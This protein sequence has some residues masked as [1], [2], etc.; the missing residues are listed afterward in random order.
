MQTY[1]NIKKIHIFASITNQFITMRK[2]LFA[3]AILALSFTACKDNNS[4]ATEGAEEGAATEV[5]HKTRIDGGVAY[6]NIDSLLAKYDLATELRNSFEAKYNKID[7]DLTARYS[8]LERDMMDAQEKV[9]KGLVTRA[10]A[11]ELEEKLVKQQQRFVQ[12]REKR[13]GELAEEEQVINNRLYYAVTDYLKE[14]NADFKYS[15]IMSTGAT[16]PVLH[17][18]PEF[19]ITSEVLAALNEAYAKEKAAEAAE[20]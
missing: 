12:D 9:Q 20:K 10:Q 7:K 2:I 3:A 18:D 16:G 13:M 1:T 6:I 14:Y 11:A 4:A 17:A 8:R 5:N 19:D 15:M